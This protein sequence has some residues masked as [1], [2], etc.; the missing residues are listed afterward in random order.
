MTEVCSCM[1]CKSERYDAI[2]KLNHHRAGIIERCM[3]MLGDVPGDTLEDRLTKLQGWYLEMQFLV[4]DLKHRLEVAEA[5]CRLT[6]P[7]VSTVQVSG[8][9]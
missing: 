8:D 5:V 1:R 4:G 6:R 9:K 3:D 2:S 7:D